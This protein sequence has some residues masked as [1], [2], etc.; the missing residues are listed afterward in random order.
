MAMKVQEAMQM[1]FFHFVKTPNVGEREGNVCG[2]LN[3]F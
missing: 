3:A 1:A 2:G